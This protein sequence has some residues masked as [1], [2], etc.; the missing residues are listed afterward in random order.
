MNLVVTNKFEIHKNENFIVPHKH[1][2]RMKF[3]KKNFIYFCFISLFTNWRK[4]ISFPYFKFPFSVTFYRNCKRSISCREPRLLMMFSW[5][6]SVK[7]SYKER[8]WFNLYVLGLLCRLF[9]YYP[10]FRLSDWFFGSPKQC[11]LWIDY[12]FNIASEN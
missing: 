8:I 6:L 12:I 9:D 5:W 7:V 2:R 1:T 3:L 4:T 11:L 10:N